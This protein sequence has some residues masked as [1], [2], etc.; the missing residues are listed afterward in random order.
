VTFKFGDPDYEFQ[1]LRRQFQ[2]FAPPPGKYVEL[3][4]DEKMVEKMFAIMASLKQDLKP[5]RLITKREICAADKEFIE[6]FM[7]LDPRDRPSVEEILAHEWWGNEE[8]V[9]R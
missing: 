5:F 1:V 8:D 9:Q 2:F 7:K 4:V 3:F 6:W